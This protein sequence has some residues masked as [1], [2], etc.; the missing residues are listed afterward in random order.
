MSALR[1]CA[2]VMAALLVAP[3]V[4]AQAAAEEK[5]LVLLPLAGKGLPQKQRRALDT[6]LATKVAAMSSYRV[7]S[8]SDIEAEFGLERVKDLVGCDNVKCAAEITG[9]LDA[10][11]VVHGSVRALERQLLITLSLIDVRS[12]EPTRRGQ[13][14]TKQLPKYYEYG[15]EVAV[16]SMLGVLPIPSPPWEPSARSLYVPPEKMSWDPKA[17][18]KLYREGREFY[19]AG[20]WGR[21]VPYFERCLRADSRVSRCQYD[22]GNA[23]ARLRDNRRASDAYK[24]YLTME[25]KGE[26]SDFARWFVETYEKYGDRVKVNW[27]K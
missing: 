22:I 7:I 15:L 14:K 26:K 3:G 9:P 6:S 4:R 12:V 16:R 21:A 19:D 20:N 8:F 11:Y 24:R 23:H 25:P 27:T 17:A 2:C 5:V 18:K 1:I 10:R 13:G